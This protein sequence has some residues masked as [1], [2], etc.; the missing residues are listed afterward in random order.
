[1]CVCDNTN[2]VSALNRG[3]SKN[4]MARHLLRIMSLMQFEFGFAVYAVYIWTH[5]NL[6][7]DTLSRAFDEDSKM[8]V[9]AAEVDEF[10][11]RR[12]PTLVREGVEE[13]A[14]HFIFADWVHRS[15]E[16]RPLK[17]GTRESSEAR[18][19]DELNA[20]ARA[21][22]QARGPPEEASQ[23]A[24]PQVETFRSIPTLRCT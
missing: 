17:E 3:R 24:A 9:S 22:A 23:P 4:R 20:H 18:R 15:F 7:C 2:V 11:A 14:R 21:L 6:L 19:F 8:G 5:H 10:M 12:Y 13:E 16:L 1:M